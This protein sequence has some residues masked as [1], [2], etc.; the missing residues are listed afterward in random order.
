MKTNYNNIDRDNKIIINK[1]SLRIK[2][3]TKREQVFTFN[4]LNP[5]TLMFDTITVGTNFL[6]D[7]DTF[8]ITV[9]H[10]SWLPQNDGEIM[11]GVFDSEGGSYD[12]FEVYVNLEENNT[13]ELMK[14]I[15]DFVLAVLYGN[16]GLINQYKYKIN[17]NGKLVK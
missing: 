9:T 6:D 5:A 15:E 2:K 10:D 3:D 7:F 14:A 16:N 1:N 13:K 12:G 4:V 8:G 17:E 11:Y